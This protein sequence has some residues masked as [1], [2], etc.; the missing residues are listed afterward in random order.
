M[1]LRRTIITKPLW[2]QVDGMFKTELE[3]NADYCHVVTVAE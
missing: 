2:S 1:V 3:I